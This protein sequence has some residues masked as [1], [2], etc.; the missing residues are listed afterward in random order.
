MERMIRCTWQSIP[1]FKLLEDDFLHPL[2]GFWVCVLRGEKGQE[3]R[4]GLPLVVVLELV[5]QPDSV[6]CMG[7]K[8]GREGGRISRQLGEA[9]AVGAEAHGPSQG[10]VRVGFLPGDDEGAVGRGCGGEGEEVD[11]EER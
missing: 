10:V 5:D 1:R 2:V 3:R 4:G 7:H 11:E 6:R 8:V 9:V